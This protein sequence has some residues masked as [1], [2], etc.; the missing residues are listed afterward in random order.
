MFV[1]L[2][3]PSP[4]RVAKHGPNAS[5]KG[6]LTVQVALYAPFLHLSS[7][8]SWG[9]SK[10]EWIFRSTSQ[11]SKPRRFDWMSISPSFIPKL[12]STLSASANLSTVNLSWRHEGKWCLTH[13]KFN[14]PSNYEV[15][16][17]SFPLFSAVWRLVRKEG[18]RVFQFPPSKKWWKS[19]AGTTLRTVVF[20]WCFHLAWS[21]NNIFYFLNHFWFR[22]KWT[23]IRHIYYITYI[24]PHI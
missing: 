3:T 6:K 12:P 11:D 7:V 5:S 16:T 20:F 2:L 23:L 4:Q 17:H 15:V 14:P 21:V 24:I 19:G 8:T 22:N 18:G 1:P 13:G 10:L 9:S